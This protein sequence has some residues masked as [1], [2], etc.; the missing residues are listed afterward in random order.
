MQDPEIGQYG[1]FAGQHCAASHVAPVAQ[2]IDAPP[3]ALHAV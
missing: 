2:H 3:G 1:L